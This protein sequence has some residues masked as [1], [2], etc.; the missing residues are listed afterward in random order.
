M[1]ATHLATHAPV[2]TASQSMAVLVDPINLECLSFQLGTVSYAIDILKVQEIRAYEQPTR[3]VNTPVFVK[4]VLNLRGVIVPVIDL[5]V[6][7]D[8][9]QADFTTSTVTMILNLDRGVVGA[10]V[11]SVSDV[12]DLSPTQIKP[13]PH[14]DSAMPAHC[15]T[16]IATVTT[17]D[18]ERLLMLL[19][20]DSVLALHAQPAAAALLQ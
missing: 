18:A 12:V 14:F 2:H 7:L 5:R 16:G 3:M 19:D 11:D 6:K 10:V 4:G 20:I 17:G 8:L 15:I 9:A 1:T 13:A